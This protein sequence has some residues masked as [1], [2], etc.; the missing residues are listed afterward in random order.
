MSGRMVRACAATI[1]CGARKGSPNGSKFLTAIHAILN[2]AGR[3]RK[4]LHI[5]VDYRPLPWGKGYIDFV[6][7]RTTITCLDC[8]RSEGEPG[9]VGQG[10][11]NRRQSADRTSR[12]RRNRGGAGRRHHQTP[13]TNGPD[14]L[15][16]VVRQYGRVPQ[17]DHLHRRREGHPPLPRHPHRTIH[18]QA[19]LRG[20]GLVAHL[21]A[22]AA[23]RG[24]S[25]VQ[26]SAD[27]ER[28]A[29]RGGEA[30]VSAHSRRRPADGDPLR[31]AQQPGVLSSGIPGVARRRVAGRGGGAADQQGA[32]HCRFFLPCAPWVCRSTTPIRI[33]AIAQIF[34]T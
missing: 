33:S 26:Q 28:A 16:S 1:R 27:R 14:Y 8:A 19:E 24:A 11:F 34:C 22:A 6:A 5:V 9:Y 20:N 3:T 7:N 30:P 13:R 17:R 10:D 2:A 23:A 25:P 32:H 15:R 12:A 4:R 18:R 31:H 29:P 21:R